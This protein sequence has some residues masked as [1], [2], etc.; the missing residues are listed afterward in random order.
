MTPTAHDIVGIGNA[1]VDVIARSSDTVLNRHGMAKGGMAL[2]DE[3]AAD[4]LYAR[5]SAAQE[6]SGGSAANTIAGIASF[7]GRTAFIGKVKDD[8][9]GRIFAHD[10]L[11]QGVLYR[12]PP[13]IEGPATARCLILVTPDAQRTMNTHLGACV[14][15][16]SEDIDPALIAESGILYLEGY[17]FDPPH[18]K[19]AFRKAAAIA[20]AAGRKVALTLSDR[21][22]VNRHLGEFQQLIA[23]HVD[24][25][26]ANEAEIAELCG[27]D[28]I[29]AAADYLAGHV[30][31][32]AITRSEKG[33]LIVS[34]GDRI[35]IP[36]APVARLL[37]TT[38]AGDLYAAGL[39]HGLSRGQSLAESGWLGSLAAAEVI[40]Q[41]GA[42]PQTRLADLERERAA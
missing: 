42:R 37:D 18:A 20:R 40:G 4:R 31:I 41:Y 1:I 21:F 34:G 6:R 5:M 35:A 9:L 8:A 15:L 2:I 38:G 7:G 29:G 13:A 12:T 17:L 32:A 10:L 33:S 36:A 30:E 24:I 39:L 22:C 25:L 23:D 26:F 27:H 16:T 14:E 11:S 3:E 19:A 28:D